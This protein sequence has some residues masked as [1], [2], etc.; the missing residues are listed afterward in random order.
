MTGNP[1]RLFSMIPQNIGL[2]KKDLQKVAD[3]NSEFGIAHKKKARDILDDWKKGNPQRSSGVKIES[4]QVK[5]MKQFAGNYAG[6]YA[7]QIMGNN[8][9]LG[10][11][12][13]DHEESLFPHPH[14]VTPTLPPR[15]PEH[16]TYPSD[17]FVSQPA[18][19]ETK[20]NELNTNR[21]DSLNCTFDKYVDDECTDEDD[22]FEEFQLSNWEFD[23]PMPTWLS[24]VIERQKSLTSQTDLSA[25]FESS[26][27]LEHIDSVK[28][29]AIVGPRVCLDIVPQSIHAS[30]LTASH[31]AY[32]HY[33]STSGESLYVSYP[34]EPILAEASAHL[35]HRIART[36]YLSQLVHAVRSGHVEGGFRGELVGRL[37]ALFAWD[38]AQGPPNAID[39]HFS[40]ALCVGEYLEQL[41]AGGR[42]KVKEI[43]EESAVDSSVM[44]NFLSGEMF[45]THFVPLR[46]TQSRVDLPRCINRG[47][48]IQCKRGQTGIDLILPVILPPSSNTN[49]HAE[50]QNLFTVEDASQSATSV[51]DSDTYSTASASSVSTPLGIFSWVGSTDIADLDQRIS[52][53]L[54]QCRNYQDSRDTQEVYARQSVSMTYSGITTAPFLT[55]YQQFGGEASITS[56]ADKVGEEDKGKEIVSSTKPASKRKYESLEQEE[57]RKQYQMSIGLFGL[58]NEVYKCF[59][60]D[61]EEDRI[62][63]LL[64]KLAQSHPDP[65]KFHASRKDKYVV[66]RNNPLQY[67]PDS[68][69]KANEISF[70]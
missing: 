39:V 63:E 45:F 17:S 12:K 70:S 13:D 9:I 57:Q 40:R 66:I 54:I 46:Y 5:K 56:L 41:I 59:D 49:R 15:T 16:Q 2:H 19:N 53:I 62:F 31:L 7:T 65:V 28:A 52:C 23:E 64:Q 44:V 27:K 38:K 42:K 4:F 18:R 55:L 26:L 61:P 29:L 48:A 35:M 25:R 21:R 11:K 24:K 32:V 10:T 20:M 36:R 51:Q 30:Q 50:S 33:I 60:D 1:L 37:L 34:S 69:I 8:I 3:E 47:A 6:D 58:N 68:Y 14:V 43:L 22:V 67:H